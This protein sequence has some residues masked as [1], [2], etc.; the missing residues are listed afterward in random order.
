MAFTPIATVADLY[1]SSVGTTFLAQYMDGEAAQSATTG[2][3]TS[4]PA[5]PSVQRVNVLPQLANVNPL[6]AIVVVVAALYGLKMLR[7]WNRHGDFH[8]AK[9]GLYFGAMATLWVAALMPLVKAILAKYNLG[10][11]SSYV[12]NA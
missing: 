8:E 2:A 12:L 1:G 9:A 6:V 5:G 7:E 3:A 10:P 4:T 11:I